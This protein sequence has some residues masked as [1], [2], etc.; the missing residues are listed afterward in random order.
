MVV[1]ILVTIVIF[2][3]ISVIIRCEGL[4]CGHKI[5]GFFYLLIFIFLSVYR[6]F[7]RSILEYTY[8][9]VYLVLFCRD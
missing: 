3:I 9:L 8:F 4:K 5:P 1:E 6:S 7:L 2:M